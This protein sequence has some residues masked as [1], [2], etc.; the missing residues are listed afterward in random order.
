M[1][2]LRILREHPVWSSVAAVI[3]FLFVGFPVWLGTV[4]PLFSDRVFLDVARENGWW[5]VSR[6]GLLYGWATV[7]LGCASVVLLGWLIAE[8]RRRELE[9]GRGVDLPVLADPFARPRIGAVEVP[10]TQL[11][12]Q[13]NAAS[14]AAP[15][16]DVEPPRISVT[17]SGGEA[18]RVTVT[19]LGPALSLVAHVQFRAIELTRGTVRTPI[20]VAHQH[21]IP[22]FPRA[23]GGGNVSDYRLARLDERMISLYGESN[24]MLQY[25]Q[26]EFSESLSVV[27][28]I[29][30]L[31]SD[32]SN[33]LKEIG[34]WLL[35]VE[36][37]A[38]SHE[39]I[40]A[41][42]PETRG[43]EAKQ[44]ASG[45]LDAAVSAMS[46][47]WRPEPDGLHLR[48]TS[49]DVRALK[50]LSVEILSATWWSGKAWVVAPDPGEF[51][52]SEMRGVDT[53]Y[54]EHPLDYPAL[55][56]EGAGLWFEGKDQ[57]KHY[58]RKLGQ[59]QL[60]VRVS[61]EGFP[62]RTAT[63]QCEWSDSTKPA[64]PMAN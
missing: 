57:R 18:V 22:F 19:N 47:D 23:V 35:R 58:I 38:R 8:V 52:P 44:D 28:S 36:L 5:W 55:H 2:P 59:W 39:L 49:H 64:L 37:A 29:A 12:L 7:G 16:Q 32:K 4:W 11:Q 51:P 1:S 9:V 45:A 40:A 13:P 27:I 48:L 61:A 14:P 15:L 25:I 3:G 63:L 6:V 21:R 42:R 46:I 34:R 50:R 20:T 10:A 24:D 53:I 31:S 56:L 26:P 62:I 41:V 33:N 30:L 60:A 17:A 54:P 43:D